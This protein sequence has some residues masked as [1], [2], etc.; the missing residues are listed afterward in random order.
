[1]GEQGSCAGA[2]GVCLD[3]ELRVDAIREA[4]FGPSRSW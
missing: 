4:E 3:D 1:M 2:N